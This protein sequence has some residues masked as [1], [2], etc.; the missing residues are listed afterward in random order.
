MVY[1]RFNST[2]VSGSVAVPKDG[3]EFF[4]FT[5]TNYNNPTDIFIR[6][7]TS[8]LSMCGGNS[9]SVSL[10]SGF[11]AEMHSLLDMAQSLS[12]LRVPSKDPN[13]N[14]ITVQGFL[15]TPPDF[16]KTKTYPLAFLI[17]GGP[18]SP[19]DNSWSYRWNPQ[20]YAAYGYITVLIN[21]QGSPGWGQQFT[22]SIQG[23]YGTLP[24]GDL[25][26]SINWLIEESEWKNSIDSNR[27]AALGAS[28]GGYTINWLAGHNINLKY[29]SVKDQVKND[30]GVI[31]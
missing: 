7:P 5:E 6:C 14:P 23:R 16:D 28:F 21:F 1:T 25:I 29:P 9:P 31:D 13:G 4:L 15:L 11:N 30:C 22:D 18:Q 19:W 17:H 2:G 8:D 26:N 10:T 3:D 20:I 27:M 12:I 24:Y